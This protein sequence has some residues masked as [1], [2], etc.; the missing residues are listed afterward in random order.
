MQGSHMSLLSAFFSS[1]NLP[2]EGGWWGELQAPPGIRAHCQET[3]HGIVCRGHA[4]ACKHGQA[5]E[6]RRA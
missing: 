6:G 2:R 4:A 5:H 3:C 1:L